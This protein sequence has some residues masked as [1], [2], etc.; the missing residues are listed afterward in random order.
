LCFEAEVTTVFT[1]L[2]AMKGLP[3]EDTY[4]NIFNAYL[5][6]GQTSVSN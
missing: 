2:D 5:E 1:D 3:L 4:K 6:D